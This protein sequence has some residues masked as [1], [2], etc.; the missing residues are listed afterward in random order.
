MNRDLL[1]FL[2]CCCIAYASEGGGTGAGTAVGAAEYVDWIIGAPYP[3]PHGAE[4]DRDNPAA[5][6]A[7][8][9]C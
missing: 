1:G 3:A 2:A 4:I 8:A 6:V 9:F 7:A 5:A